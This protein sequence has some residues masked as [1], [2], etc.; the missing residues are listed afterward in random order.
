MKHFTLLL[1]LISFNTYSQE[2]EGDLQLPVTDLS[3][4]ERQEEEVPP[5]IDEVEMK[6]K[7]AKKIKTKTKKTVIK[8]E[9][10]ST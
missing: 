8:S 6:Q 3:E 9:K 10:E 7:K 2:K 5:T 1:L 4:I